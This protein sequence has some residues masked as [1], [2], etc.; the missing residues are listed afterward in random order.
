M[1]SYVEEIVPQLT[2]P[3]SDNNYGSA[4]TCDVAC[5]QALSKRIHYG[6]YP[7]IHPAY[8]LH[9]ILFKKTT[10][11]KNKQTKKTK[12]KKNK[13]SCKNLQFVV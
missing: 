6:K 10:K 8:K 9:T 1:K 11:N 3:G 4:A 5:L 7:L 12:T 13:K 2:S